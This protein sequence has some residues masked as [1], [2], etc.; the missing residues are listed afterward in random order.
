MTTKKH[1]PFRPGIRGNLSTLDKIRVA[2]PWFPCPGF[3]MDPRQTIN[4]FERWYK[5]PNKA[6]RVYWIANKDQHA[7]IMAIVKAASKG[8]AK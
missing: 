2:R 3:V 5:R 8:K 4:K 1:E 6:W 7:K